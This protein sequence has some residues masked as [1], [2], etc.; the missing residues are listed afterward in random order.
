MVATQCGREV[1]FRA[2]GILHFVFAMLGLSVYFSLSMDIWCII[3]YMLAGRTYANT[4][5]IIERE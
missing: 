5:K 4:R 3:S 1:F 2:V